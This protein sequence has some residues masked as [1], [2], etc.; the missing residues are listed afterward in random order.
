M[1][2]GNRIGWVL[3]ACVALGVV[4]MLVSG[5]DER[6]NSTPTADQAPESEHSCLIAY[7]QLEGDQAVGRATNDCGQTI[8]S[9]KV[10]MQVTNKNDST[11]LASP[12]AFVSNLAPNQ[13]AVFQEY[14]APNASV[15][16]KVEVVKTE[17]F[18]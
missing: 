4:P 6:S 10:E 18:K 8:S 12:V 2:R 3:G 17:A 7:A 1:K 13:A 5:C 15:Y 14:A 11:V 16:A 9:G